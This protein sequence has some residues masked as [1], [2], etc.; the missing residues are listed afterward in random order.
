MTSARRHAIPL[1]V[2]VLTVGSCSGGDDSAV[3]AETTS[4]VTSLPSAVPAVATSTA[5]PSTAQ[6]AEPAPTTTTRPPPH[7]GAFDQTIDL[8]TPPD[9]SGIRPELRWSAVGGADHYGVYLYA[10]DGSIYWSW[11][12]RATAV[13]VGGEP[14][15]VDSAPGPSVV[16]GMTWAV[17]AYDADLLPLA[18]SPLGAIAP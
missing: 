3:V 4:G 8:L 17:I 15:L 1:L 12:G 14:R 10:P 7:F 11:S 16:D 6:P 2:A 9:G 18:I 5:A 13:P